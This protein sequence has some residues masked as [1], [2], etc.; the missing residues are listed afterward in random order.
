MMFAS[1]ANR[2]KESDMTQ[3][4]EGNF[5]K[6][7]NTGK[8][9]LHCYIRLQGQPSRGTKACTT[10]ARPGQKMLNSYN[11]VW[12]EKIINHRKISAATHVRQHHQLSANQ[13]HLF[14][15]QYCEGT[16]PGQ[17]LEA[18]QWQHADL[19]EHEWEIY[20][21]LTILLGVGGTYYNEHTI[22]NKC[23]PQS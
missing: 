9:K 8:V 4:T 5:P 2:L 14:E 15:F 22:D 20:P 1:K 18:A 10:V 7:F 6:K 17:Q 13:R 11:S 19:Q 21:V 12:K 23:R 3:F 16:R